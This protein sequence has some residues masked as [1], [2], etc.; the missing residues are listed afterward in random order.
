MGQEQQGH[1]VDEDNV[2][3]ASE[4]DGDAGPD[5]Q[6]ESGLEERGSASAIVESVMQRESGLEERGSASDIVE[7]VFEDESAISGKSPEESLAEC[8]GEPETLA[9]DSYIWTQLGV[10]AAAT[11]DDSSVTPSST[12]A[13]FEGAT[14]GLAR[15]RL[16]LS[17]T[18]SASALFSSVFTSCA[19]DCASLVGASATAPDILDA[20]RPEYAPTVGRKT[21][22]LSDVTWSAP[23]GNNP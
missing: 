18:A 9:H 13:A 16:R 20:S 1:E 14:V 15:G 6:Q 21:V 22:A 19:F 12:L 10:D 2:A 4:L 5:M 8:D 23:V 3:I 17:S 11:A 7:S